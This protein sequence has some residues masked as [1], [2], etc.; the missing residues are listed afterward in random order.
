M[1]LPG[2]EEGSAWKTVKVTNIWVDN[3]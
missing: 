2:S 3:R 1:D